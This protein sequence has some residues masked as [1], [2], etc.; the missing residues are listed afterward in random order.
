MSK[1]IFAAVVPATRRD[2]EAN[3]FT[4]FS[5]DVSF[6][7]KRSTAAIVPPLA[8]PV[9]RAASMTSGS[10]SAMAA[11]FVSVRSYFSRAFDSIASPTSSAN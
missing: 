7:V 8:R 5:L 9:V 2:L 4:R 6:D 3:G 10:R 11:W 1:A